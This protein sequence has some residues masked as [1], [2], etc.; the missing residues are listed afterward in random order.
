V[1]Q[2]SRQFSKQLSE[3]LVVAELARRGIFATPFSGTI[4]DY[5]ILVFKRGKSTPVQVKSS[6]IGN[7][8]VFNVEYDYLIIEQEEGNSH[9][10]VSKREMAQWKKDLIFVIIFIGD[11]L[12]E[13]SFYICNNS[14]IQEIIYNNYV[15]VLQRHE[16]IRPRKLNSRGSAY[17]EDDLSDFKDNW[18]LICGNNPFESVCKLA[19]DGG[20]WCWR[21]PCTT[22]GNGHIRYAFI[23]MSLGKSPDEDGWITRKD[24]NDG[25]LFSKFGSFHDPPRSRLEKDKITEIC[26]NASIIYIADNCIFPEWLGYLGLILIHMKESSSYESL[27]SSWAKQL[28]EYLVREDNEENSQKGHFLDEIINGGRLLN[29]Q[30]LERIEE[31]IIGFTPTN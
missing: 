8:K 12:G 13:D 2:L 7:I 30:D 27:S 15:S 19:S 11:K 1:G 29:I 23:E 22:C 3:Y 24:V 31:H 20:G 18:R 6:T 17:S 10:S 16:G 4:P 21:M 28:K 9:V 14:D 26:L 5:D 25:V